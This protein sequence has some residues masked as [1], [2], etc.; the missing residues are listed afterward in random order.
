MRERV[1]QMHGTF[2]IES[3]VGQGVTVRVALPVA[4][5]SLEGRLINDSVN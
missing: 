4:T 1:K 5:A 3:I 2:L